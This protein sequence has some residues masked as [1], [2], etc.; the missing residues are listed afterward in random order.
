MLSKQEFKVM[1]F[2]VESLLLFSGVYM[3]KFQNF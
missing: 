1:L 3:K 2:V